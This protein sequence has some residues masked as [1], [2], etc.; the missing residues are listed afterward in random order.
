MTFLN[1]ES[2]KNNDDIRLK[3]L[4]NI[5]R[6]RGGLIGQSMRRHN[7]SNQWGVTK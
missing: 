5:D 3:R 1:T 6:K 7:R 2:T 4:S